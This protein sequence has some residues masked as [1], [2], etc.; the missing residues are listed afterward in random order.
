MSA[1]HPVAGP[2]A[3]GGRLDAARRRYPDAP[4]PWIDLSTGISPH[5][6]P[7]PSVAPEA[8]TRLPDE[9]AFAAFEAAARG[10]YRASAELAV[11]PGAGAQAFIQMLPRIFPAQRV[12]VLGFTY[13]EHAACWS[14]AGAT[15]A[16]VETPDA[17]AAADVGVIVNPNN[18]DGRM[19]A[20]REIMALAR[21]MTRKGGLLVVDESFMD[22]TPAS[23]VVPYITAERIVVLRSLGKAYGLAGMRLGV[24]ICAA[25]HAALIRAALGPWAVSGPALAIGARALA[26]SRWLHAAAAACA[27]EA[28]RLDGALARANFSILGGTQLFR[29]ARHERAMDRFARLCEA[30]VLVRPFPEKPE[31]LRFGLPGGED[32]W[33]RLSAAL[34]IG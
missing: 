2:I 19:L 5:P 24:A 8:W 33:R 34:E 30:G 28:A 12:A 29:L 26:D 7:L 16:A 32:A 27:T 11:T 31:W 18:P 6:Y 1:H 22:F 9:D 14:A 20:P 10:A 13:A 21:E 17:L 3:H 25:P 23:S 4:Q 15:V